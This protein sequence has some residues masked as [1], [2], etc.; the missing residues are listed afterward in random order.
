MTKPLDIA[1]ILMMTGYPS[2]TPS[3]NPSLRLH[4]EI[5]FFCEVVRPILAPLTEPNMISDALLHTAIAC[6]IKAALDE[7]IGAGDITAGLIP[8]HVQA[9]ARIITREP[10]VLAGRPWVEATCKAFNPRITLYWPVAEGAEIA[11]NGTVFEMSG[12]RAHY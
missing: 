6:N 9:H 12:H 10:M 2:F 7:D 1:I 5:P 8:A 3:G 4:K 11:P